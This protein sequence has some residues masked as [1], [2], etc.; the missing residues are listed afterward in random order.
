LRSA[1]TKAYGAIDWIARFQNAGPF[2]V[3]RCVLVEMRE[4]LPEVR[5]PVDV[6]LKARRRIPEEILGPD[7]LRRAWSPIE[8]RPCL[9]ANPEP[10]RGGFTVKR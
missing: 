2:A 4:L 6:I 7:E 8:G 1:H 5:G 9:K 10:L 3:A